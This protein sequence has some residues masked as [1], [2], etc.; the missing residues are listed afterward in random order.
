MYLRFFT[1]TLAMLLP[2]AAAAPAGLLV[3]SLGERP[4]SSRIFAAGLDGTNARPISPGEG[5]DRAPA[6]SPD[7]KWIAYHSVD[8]AGIERVFVTPLAGGK[9]G[10]GQIGS[11]PQWS[12]DGAALY[13]TRKAQNRPWI[14]RADFAGGKMERPRQIVAGQ[15]PRISP[16]GRRMALLTTVVAEGEE[17]WQLQILDL[18]DLKPRLRLTLPTALGQV[19][20]AA[21]NPQ[22]DRLLLSSVHQRRHAVHLVDLSFPEPRPLFQGAIQER[23]Y[24]A[25]LP[26]GAIV[27]WQLAP[28]GPQLSRAATD[29][30]APTVLLRPGSR[31]SRA[32][33][34]TAWGPPPARQAAAPAAPAAPPPAAPAPV[35]PA[36]APAPAPPVEAGDDIWGPAIKLHGP[37]LFNVEQERSP[38]SV[39]VARPGDKDFS[40]ELTAGAAGQPRRRR[41]MGLTIDMNDGS[42][43]RGTLIESGPTWLTLQGRPPSGKVRLIDNQRLDSA[44]FVDGFRL[45]VRRRGERLIL[46]LDGKELISR[47]LL[48]GPV[49]QVSLTLENFDAGAAGFPLTSLDLHLPVP[50]PGGAAAA[51]DQPGSRV[52]G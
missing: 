24:A 39:P 4:G 48:H 51:P 52:A 49:A 31:E 34:I 38:V 1:I 29:G 25:W 13:F 42:M 8:A 12:V 22:G 50:P 18:P 46:L 43:Y 45:T 36:P 28:D 10:P 26:D 17:H 20:D 32:L 27:F 40:I 11:H 2:A 33:E 30:A 3:F 41:A 9:P 7:G 37:K 6:I 23:A 16:D 47:P 15:L 44:R 19:A 21:W 14:F 35:P 5:V